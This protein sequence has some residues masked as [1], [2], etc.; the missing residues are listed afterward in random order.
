MPFIFEDEL[1]EQRRR[2]LL[3]RFRGQFL[4]ERMV[5]IEFLPP[6][7]RAPV[8]SFQPNGFELF[9]M[10]G[11]VWEHVENCWNESYKNAPARGVPASRRNRLT[12]EPAQRGR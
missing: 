10:L 1:A 3:P 4:F 5:S 7:P 9:D 2:R 8:G 12:G 11:N 6:A